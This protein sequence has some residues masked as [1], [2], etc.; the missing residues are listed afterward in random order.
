MKLSERPEFKTCIFV[1]SEKHWDNN[2][3]NIIHA[4]SEVGFVIVSKKSDLKEMAYFEQ[5]VSFSWDDDWRAPI[6]RFYSLE[7]KKKAEIIISR[8]ME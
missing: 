4:L 1:G 3:K 2:K 6:L 5:E 7:D 8:F